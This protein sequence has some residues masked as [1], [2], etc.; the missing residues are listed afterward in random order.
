MLKSAEKIGK[1][2]TF[3]EVH[4]TLKEMEKD[5]IISISIKK[6]IH[7]SEKKTRVKT[8]LDPGNK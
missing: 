6:Y 3:E 4:K 8:S 5:P 7:V 1:K 2:V